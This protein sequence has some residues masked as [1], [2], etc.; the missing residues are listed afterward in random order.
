M[1]DRRWPRPPYI[2]ATALLGCALA[3][4]VITLAYDRRTAA[5]FVAVAFGVFVLLGA[6]AALLMLL[7]RRLPRPRSP[8]VRLAL[9]NIHR[10]GAVTPSVVLSLG[11]GLAL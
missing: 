7:A 3:G 10:P 9:S 11:H 8:V 1:P 5:I 6:I 2:A 4:L